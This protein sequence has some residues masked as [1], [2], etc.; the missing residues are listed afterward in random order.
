MNRILATTDL[1]ERSAW[2][3]ERAVQLASKMNAC[4]IVLHVTDPNAPPAVTETLREEAQKLVAAQLAAFPAARNAPPEVR[5]LAGRPIEVIVTTAASL[6]ADLIVIGRHEKHVFLDLFR[7]STGERV[8]RLGN[9]P[10]LVVSK[11]PAADYRRVLVAL[12]FSMPSR[13]ALEYAAMTFP[14]AD[15]HVL[16][17]WVMPYRGLLIDT[18][19]RAVASFRRMIEEQVAEYLAGL[20]AWFP[21]L[22]ASTRE[23][24]PTVAIRESVQELHADLLVLGTHGR[25]GVARAL[26]GSVTEDLLKDP[27]CDVLA[28]AGW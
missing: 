22:H 14:G 3:T 1:S 15:F 20:P 2:A 4:A 25:T 26:I 8:L 9:T 10:V 21:K 27:P 17:A 19:D 18:A 12:D 11:R 13:L 24:S 28:V 16:H 6:P 23:S 7:G 5:V